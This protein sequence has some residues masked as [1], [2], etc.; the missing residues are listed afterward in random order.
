MS[1]HRRRHYHQYRHRHYHLFHCHHYHRCHH[2]R[3]HYH[4]YQHRHYHRCLHRR[5]HYHRCHHRRRHY[6]QYH[7]RRHR[8]CHHHRHSH[9]Y[10]H[11]GSRHYHQYRPRRRSCRGGVIN[12][13]TVTVFSFDS[14]PYVTIIATSISFVVRNVSASL[15]S[16][17]LLNWSD[18]HTDRKECTRR[19]TTEPE[20]SFQLSEVHTAQ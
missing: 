5:R 12:S 18:R 13:T 2:R 9:Q 17:T 20:R 11:R 3:R 15:A 10:H 8:R 6:N 14:C 1:S 4:Q 7:R 19:S 16:S